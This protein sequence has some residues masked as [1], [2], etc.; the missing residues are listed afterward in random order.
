MRFFGNYYRAI[1]SF[2]RAVG[3]FGRFG[4]WGIW[5]GLSVNTLALIYPEPCRGSKVESVERVGS[6][7]F[8]RKGEG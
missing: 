3:K 8:G 1:F 5:D 2:R 6:F 4:L 7:L